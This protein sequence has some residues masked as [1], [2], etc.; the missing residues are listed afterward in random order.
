MK[1]ATPYKSVQFAMARKDS[2]VGLDE[3]CHQYDCAKST[4]VLVSWPV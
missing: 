3:N 2:R 1:G 4:C